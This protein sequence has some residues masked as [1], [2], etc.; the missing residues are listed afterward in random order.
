MRDASFGVV[1]VGGGPGGLAVSQ[2]LGERGISH[3]VLERG[4]C[5]GWMWHHVY[6][7]LRLHT[8]K[9]LSSL[10]GMAFPAG[11]SLFPSRSEL[12]SYLERY[13]DRFAL[14]V[15]MGLE[16]TALASEDVG[17]AVETTGGVFR[18]KVVVVATGIMSSPVLPSALGLS[19]YSGQVMHSTEYR[20]PDQIKG[21]SVLVVGIGNSGAEIGSELASA[22]RDVTLSVRSGANVIPRSIAGVPSQYLGWAMGWLPRGAQRGVVR[23]TGLVGGLLRRGASGLPRKTE[24]D[25]CNDQPVIGR[26]ILEHIEGER[27]RV[28]GGVEEFCG[29]RVRFTGGTEWSGESV[30]LA[31]GYRAA[32]EWM[33]R[34]AVRDECGFAERRGPGGKR[35]VSGTVFRGAQLR[36][37]RGPV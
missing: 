23:G 13:A 31:T 24:A 21:R 16:A 6:D 20:R 11:T 18:S 2:Q 26:S 30:V 29:D 36:R 27:V 10:P 3:V 17:W 34:Y 22:G 15:R 1:V 35:A 5:A 9:H 8:G 32:L 33:G 7:S 4:D 19:G 37:A 28:V 25:G 12:V 14:P